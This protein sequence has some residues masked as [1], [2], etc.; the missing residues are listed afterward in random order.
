[1]VNG[2][3][4]SRQR[5]TIH[6]CPLTIHVYLALSLSFPIF[7]AYW[8][9]SMIKTGI[10]LIILLSSLICLAQPEVLVF[11]GPQLSSARYTVNEV[12]QP[13]QFK[14]G[15][16]AGVAMKVEFDNLLYFFP[17]VYYNL[18]GYKVTLNNPSFPPTELAINN[19]TTIHTIEISPMLQLDFNKKPAHMF[20]RIGPSV[21]LALSGS[22]TFDT[23]STTGAR[24]TITRPM[25]F[26]FADY[27]L[28]TASA[29]LHLGYE[30]PRWAVYGFY[31]HG[32]GSMNN[33]DGGPAILHRIAGMAFA[34]KLG[35]KK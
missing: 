1:M 21:D 23:V 10:T 25:K 6:H 5:F 33:A 35:R 31:Q 3:S 32:I 15:L 4:G 24:G 29:N 34:W 9:L 27:G 12:K 18:K 19:N 2:Q 17:S 11:G 30:N 28:I 16:M 7:T 22:E 20:M 26:S 14:P 13:T 8:F